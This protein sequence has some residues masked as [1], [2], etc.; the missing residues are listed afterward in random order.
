MMYCT[1]H[2]GDHPQLS[3]AVV[4]VVLLLAGAYC[5]PWPLPVLSLVMTYS[6]TAS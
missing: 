5:A 2:Q 1:S 4:S 6:L 3:G